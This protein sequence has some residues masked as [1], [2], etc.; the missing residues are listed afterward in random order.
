MLDSVLGGVPGLGTRTVAWSTYA[1]E[2]PTPWRSE[3]C[4][5]K[6]SV[7]LRTVGQQWAL[8]LDHCYLTEK[9]TQ[10]AGDQEGFLIVYQPYFS[11]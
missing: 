9:E 5:G 1:S 11:L 6:A 7:P 2:V 8:L 4:T 10:D 3:R